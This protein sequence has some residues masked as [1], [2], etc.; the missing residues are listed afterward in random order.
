MRLQQQQP[1]SQGMSAVLADKHYGIAFNGLGLK[2]EFQLAT[3]KMREEIEVTRRL[4]KESLLSGQ[5]LVL[6]PPIDGL[7]ESVYPPRIV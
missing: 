3:R 1:Y 2:L 7:W 5:R 4:Y 6:K